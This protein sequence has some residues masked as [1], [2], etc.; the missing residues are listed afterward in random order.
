MVLDGCSSK[1]ATAKSGVPPWHGP[2]MILLFVNDI[3]DNAT[4][5]IKLFANDFLDFRL[6][7]SLDRSREIAVLK[8]ISS[9]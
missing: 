3:G 6:F 9:A 5:S 2:L 7:Q 8:D 4:S 1:S